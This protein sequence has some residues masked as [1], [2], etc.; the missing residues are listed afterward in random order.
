MSIQ[1]FKHGLVVVANII[2]WL[3]HIWEQI[4]QLGHHNE[5]LNQSIILNGRV[6]RIRL[7][8]VNRFVPNFIR[9]LREIFD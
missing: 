4:G 3:N 7:S 5:Y 8:G 2:L 6:K 9:L 1:E